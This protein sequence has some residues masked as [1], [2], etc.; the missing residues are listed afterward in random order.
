MCGGHY[1]NSLGLEHK[2]LSLCLRLS[3]HPINF[4]IFVKPCVALKFRRLHI[5]SNLK[6]LHNITPINCTSMLIE[7]QVSYH[8]GKKFNWQ[9]QTPHSDEIIITVDYRG[10]ESVY[11]SLAISNQFVAFLPNH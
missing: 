3:T 6:Y 4:V 2:S 1:F 10:P 5:F 7:Y 11:V 8:F 9:T